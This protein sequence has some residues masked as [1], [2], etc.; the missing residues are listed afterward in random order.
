MNISLNAFEFPM[1]IIGFSLIWGWIRFV[2]NEW[3][4]RKVSLTP[5]LVAFGLA[6]ASALLAFGWFI[7]MQ[8]FAHNDFSGYLLYENVTLKWMFITGFLF[9]SGGLL[10]GMAG[11]LR[12]SSLRWHSPF[13]AAVTAVFWF[14]AFLNYM[15]CYD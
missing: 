4:H 10:L 7:K 12:R 8:F 11:T 13:S 15:V 2:Q 9:S 6:T 14:M 1:L 3:L 5:T